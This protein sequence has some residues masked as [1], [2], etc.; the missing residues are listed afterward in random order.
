VNRRNLTRGL[1]MSLRAAVGAGVSL[2]IADFLQLE[3]PL[4]AMI[5]AVIVTDL[6][7]SQSRQL[8]WQRLVGTVAGAICGAALS[9]LLPP[10]AWAI[11]VGI[12]VAMLA[13]YA[14]R[15]PAGAKLAG[16]ACGIVMLTFSSEPW[17]YA[18]YRLVETMLGIAVAVLISFVPKLLRDHETENG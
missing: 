4:Y 15:M 16:Y 1:Q 14:A 9:P 11:A 13:C 17:S 7:P 10:A 5:A 6:S 3:F 8:G 2:A 12:L 18:F